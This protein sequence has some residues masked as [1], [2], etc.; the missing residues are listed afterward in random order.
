METMNLYQSFVEK[1]AQSTATASISELESVESTLKAEL[2]GSYKNF[3]ASFGATHNPTL[4][5]VTV[6]TDSDL[7]DLNEFVKV[8]NFVKFNEMYWSGGMPR[9][10]YAFATDC[11]GNAFC[12]E[13]SSD[14]GEVFLY[15][16]EFN[17]LESL[18]L[19]FDQLL[20]EYLSLVGV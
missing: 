18:E 19:T 20:G 4:L 8:S 17:E 16:T 13:L 6:Q 2:P 11:L 1:F 9:T 5:D 15:D 3:I 14:I 12:F 7:S 10:V